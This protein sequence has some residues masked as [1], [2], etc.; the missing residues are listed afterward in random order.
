M[1]TK[2]MP[3]SQILYLV[4]TGPGIGLTSVSL[5]LVRALDREG[6]HVGFFKPICQPHNNEVG[7][8]QSTHFLRAIHGIESPTPMSFSQ[9]ASMLLAGEKG[10][11]LEKVMEQFESSIQKSND[12]IVVEGLQP[13]AERPEL[14]EI[15]Q[16]VVRA[17]DAQVIIVSAL[18]PKSN[19]EIHHFCERIEQVARAY[20]GADDPRVLGCI[21]NKLNQP[22]E[23]RR[24]LGSVAAFECKP[25]T[26]FTAEDI[27]KN[28]PL[29]QKHQSFRLLGVIHWDKR[30]MTPRTCDMQEHLDAIVL[31]EGDMYNRR[32]THISVVAMTLH[33]MAHLLSRPGALLI[34]P[35]DR[36]DVL[37]AACMATLNGTPLAG[38]VLTGGIQP[39]PS[40]L[41]LCN[42]ALQAG[43]PLLLTEDDSYVTGAR[44]ATIDVE[45][46]ANDLE[47]MGRVMD[48]IA[49]KL[50]VPEDITKGAALT[51]DPR[52]SP[53]A[54]MH[55]LVTQARAVNQ[56]IVLPEGN[57]PRIVKA[58][59]VCQQRGIARCVLL[60]QREEI[61][62]VAE[63]QGME[64]PSD[65]QI[66]QPDLEMRERYVD[67]MVSL[68]KHK[69]M[70]PPIALQQLEDD[71]VLGTMML[72]QGEVDGLV[73]G[74]GHSTA[75]TVRPALQLIK[76]KS[77]A[78][79]SSIFFMCLPD[80]VLI[81]GDCAINPD[82]NAEEL[83]DIALQSAASAEAF[84][85]EPRV[86]L[87]SYSTG[88]SGVG[89]DVEKVREA[90][91]IAKERRPDLVID[92]PLQYDAATTISVARK[93]APDSP[94]AGRAT[95][96]IFPDLNTGNTTYK[97]VQ[98]TANLVA[99]GP[100]LQGL[101][102][103]VNDLSRGALVE[104][105]VYTIALTAIQAVNQQQQQ[106]QQQQP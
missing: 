73:S 93:K 101:K 79:V 100:M 11:L 35:G 57:E 62:R 1:I 33:N 55:R 4:P 16:D 54:F 81:Y 36:D 65:L 99:I 48:C 26:N 91:R 19:G 88:T 97:A 10:R 58:A 43:L 69:G 45:V 84:G 21:V 29:F 70:T 71:A 15:N 2:Q 38:V 37:V 6:L 105:I 12:V 17:L 52:L 56:R 30:M 7:P 44:A 14:E 90:T 75:N 80:Q 31:N 89:S 94:V 50:K 39:D 49:S 86:A 25:S 20:G 67:T 41:K 3:K 66:M 95:V 9:A 68:R 96:L 5:G 64:L 59:I 60:G 22:C 40:I 87:L 28:C 106:Q 13:T 61:T 103:P 82:P 53:P 32:V 72:A 24:V 42:K 51:R 77:G 18:C 76:T 46:P 23:R 74:A 78:R 104:D 27:R 85:I 63:A 34:T 83:A 47:R 102:R 98:R 92:G 8:E